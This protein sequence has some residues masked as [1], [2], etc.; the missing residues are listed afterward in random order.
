MGDIAASHLSERFIKEFGEDIEKACV[1][2][3]D[4]VVE[5]ELI[6]DENHEV[7]MSFVIK[8]AI[9]EVHHVFGETFFNGAYAG[10]TKED[11]AEIAEGLVNLLCG[12]DGG[13]FKAML[14]RVKK[15]FEEE[16]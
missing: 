6:E 1:M 3:G 4:F 15:V 14:A 12:G 5:Q 2:V 11:L 7:R 16:G 9:G 8:D 10:S 13:E